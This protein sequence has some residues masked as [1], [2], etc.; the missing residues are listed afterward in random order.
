MHPKYTLRRLCQ[1]DN[2]DAKKKFLAGVA[3]FANASGGDLIYGIKANDGR[4]LSVQPLDGFNPDQT[5]LTL[6]DLLL[7]HIDP[8]IYGVGFQ[9]VGLA[10]GG[11]ALVIR[12]PKTWSGAHMLT[13]NK[14][15]RF[16]TRDM[17][18]RRLMDVPEIRSSFSLAEATIE[19]I[20]RFRLERIGD[21]VADETPVVLS[22][23]SRVVVHLLPLVSF[24]PGHR[25]NL[26]AVRGNQQL[27]FKP[28]AASGWTPAVDFDG[29]YV[30]RGSRA[31]APS[32]GYSKLFRNGC[33]ETVDTEILAP[34][35]QT[36]KVI[37]SFPAGIFEKYIFESVHNSL[38][39]LREA[40]IES[41]LFVM[42]SFLG[43]RGYSMA[44]DH[45]WG[46][47]SAR[48]IG[49]DN[50]I[51]PE[52]LV[53]SLDLSGFRWLGSCDRCLTLSGMLVAGVNLSTTMSTAIGPQ[54]DDF[55]RAGTIFRDHLLNRL[56]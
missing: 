54:H 18:G 14:D 13:Y 43:V 50:L 40:G 7:A 48:A 22:G 6:R 21:I 42:L 52:L 55:K 44:V 5:L 30:H 32:E 24:E 9:P 29:D 38:A 10:A 20:R 41:P 56:D 4:P 37:K 8:K 53:E 11:Y 12:V 36:G 27:P 45:R 19:R 17:N 23:P 1:V 26:Q 16:Y 35:E 51:V 2:P 28:M 47:Y 15:N 3:S 33:I 25:C 31:S 46:N 34:W 39:V 49:R